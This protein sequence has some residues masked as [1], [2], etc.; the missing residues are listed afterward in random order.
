MTDTTDNGPGDNGPGKAYR[1]LDFLESA[2]ARA[3]RILSEYI[4]PNSRFTHYKIDDTIIFFGSARILS[5]EEAEAGLKA[6]KAEGGD[7]AQAE[8]KLEM[9]RYY[10]D[11]RELARRL[12]EWSKGLEQEDRRFVVCSGGG[13]GI[14]EA[15]NRGASEAK[16]LNVGLNISLPMEQN[17]N[18]YISRELNFEFHYFFMRKFWFAYLAKAV[19][20][21]PGGFGTLDE[22]FELL[23]LVQTG[24]IRKHMPVVLFGSQY[25]SDVINLEALERYGT[26]NA[27]DLE[28]FFRTD[29]VDE[30]YDFVTEQLQS[31]ALDIPGPRL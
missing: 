18:P 23:T 17:D 13:P 12:T 7:V 20:V 8:R 19:V 11:T 21:M 24:K 2:S 5:R 10:E 14:M 3:L 27:E 6:V 22:L 25:W 30:A 31:Y 4:E 26:I 1:N 16:G 28:L 29:S 15:A 9:S